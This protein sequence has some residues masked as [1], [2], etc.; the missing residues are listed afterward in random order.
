MVRLE[1]LERAAAD[2]TK[3]LVDRSRV[4]DA[5][6]AQLADQHARRAAVE[7]D[8]LGRDE[9]HRVAEPQARPRAQ[10]RCDALIA[11]T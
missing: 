7:G 10:H 8:V 9:A 5:L 2:P 1:A 6:R 11:A 4:V 3:A